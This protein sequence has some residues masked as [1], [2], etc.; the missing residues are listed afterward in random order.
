ML[1]QM[2][3]TVGAAHSEQEHLAQ[4]QGLHR[5]CQEADYI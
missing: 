2:Q 4:K 5:T 1:C 3:G